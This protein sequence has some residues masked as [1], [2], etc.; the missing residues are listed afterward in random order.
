EEGRRIRSLPA[1]SGQNGTN[2]NFAQLLQDKVKIRTYERGVEDE[3]LSCGTGATAVGLIA[4]ILGYDSPVI[5][6]TM[7]GNLS[8]SFRKLEEGFTDI[9]LAGPAQKVFDG[10]VII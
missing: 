3:T 5:I 7:G 10:S 9:W 4:G 1:Y 2:V 8:V 6:E